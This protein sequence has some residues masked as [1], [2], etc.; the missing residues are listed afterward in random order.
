MF[1]FFFFFFQAE[2]GIRDYKVTGV[3][4]CALPIF[5]FL[6]PL[7]L[8]LYEKAPGIRAKDFFLSPKESDRILAAERCARWLAR[9]HAL[10][11]RLGRV[12][13]LNDHLISFKGCWRRLADL[14]L[15][16]SDKARRLFGQLKTS[17]ARA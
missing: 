5:A 16:F 8:L 13:F 15:P 17:A 1:S 12:F 7:R 6:A 3:Q 10:A 2:D 14:G 9:F 11:P 4:T